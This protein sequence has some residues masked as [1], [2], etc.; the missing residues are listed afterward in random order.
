MII[1]VTNRN[2]QG[3]D[4]RNH[5]PSVGDHTMFGDDFNAEGGPNEL[6]VATADS[7]ARVSDSSSRADIS[8]QASRVLDQ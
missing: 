2:V 4:P 5:E 7:S 8:D 3:A 6:R 1:T